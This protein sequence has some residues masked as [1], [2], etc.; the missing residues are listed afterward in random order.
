MTSEVE[1]SESHVIRF[2][3]RRDDLILYDPKV[4]ARA[5]KIVNLAESVA[6]WGDLR[7]L[8]ATTSSELVDPIL[9]RVWDQWDGGEGAWEFGF[10]EDDPDVPAF[11]D[12]SALIAGFQEEQPITVKT[13]NEDG[14]ILMNPFDPV[15]MGVPEQLHRFYVEHSTMVSAWFAPTSE[16]L[17]E[18]RRVAEDIGWK[19][20]EGDSIEVPYF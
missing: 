6:T 7:R 11:H 4:A 10:D 2:I 1:S 13:E 18:I 15:A 9:A 5:R 8:Q 3:D 17:N 19:V 14:P 16:D 12:V 20:E